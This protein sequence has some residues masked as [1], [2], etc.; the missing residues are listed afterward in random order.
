MGR[1][2]AARINE[3]IFEECWIISVDIWGLN[4]HSNFYLTVKIN[5]IISV[6]S[7]LRPEDCSG[8]VTMVGVFTASPARY[9]AHKITNFYHY[10]DM[11]G[12]V[13]K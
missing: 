12:E 11:D 4:Y 3:I 6:T 7:T 2:F 5:K 9:A 10:I 8:I 13:D 1:Q